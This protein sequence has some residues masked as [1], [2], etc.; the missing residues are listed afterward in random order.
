MPSRLLVNISVEH[1]PQYLGIILKYIGLEI[2]PCSDEGMLGSTR[3]QAITVKEPSTEMSDVP[4]G[5][6][7]ST[8]LHETLVASLLSTQGAAALIFSILSDHPTHGYRCGDLE[9]HS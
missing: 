3:D 6:A 4:Q 8:Y 5:E 2:K 1:M 9:I 7:F